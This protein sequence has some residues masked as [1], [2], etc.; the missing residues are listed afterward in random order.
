MLTWRPVALDAALLELGWAVQDQ[1]GIAFWDA[2]IVAAAR[3]VDCDRLLTEDL[4]DGRDFGGV[5][6]VNPFA[7]AP[8]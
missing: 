6:I 5:V 2:L 3:V 1:Y 4:Q 8:A 7:R